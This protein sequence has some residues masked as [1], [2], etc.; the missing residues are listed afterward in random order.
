VSNEEDGGA[1][2]ADWLVRR[3]GLTGDACVVCE[4]AGVHT[5][6]EAIYIGQR[7]QSGVWMRVLGDQMHSGVAHELGARNAAVRMAR[8]M[9]LLDR[10][11]HITAQQ[12]PAA[13]PARATI[14]VAVRCGTAWGIN[15]GVGEFGIDI[16]TSP[17]MTRDDVT[18]GMDAALTTIQR[19]HP[20]I[21]VSWWFAE[22]PRDWIAPTLAAPDSPLVR[23][24]QYAGASVLDVA[25]PLGIYPA[26]TDA[27]AFATIADISTIAA[28]GPGRISLAHKADEYVT[29]ESVITAAHLYVEL[30][31]TYLEAEGASHD[32]TET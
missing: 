14:G 28:L 30:A 31:A 16:R 2:G 29:V 5:E 27:S 3:C 26:T 32:D 15:P 23:A 20:D 25:L 1:Y 19:V 4:P 17:G 8:V 18:H 22:P 7:G 11:L 21:E 9:D 13:S 12:K 6:W 10:T 24:A